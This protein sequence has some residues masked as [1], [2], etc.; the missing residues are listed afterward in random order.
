MYPTVTVLPQCIPYT[1]FPPCTV[2]PGAAGM[3]QGGVAGGVQPQT[4]FLTLFS[5][6]T[7]VCNAPVGPAGGGQPAG[8]QVVPQSTIGPIQC[9]AFGICSQTAGMPQGGQAAPQATAWIIQCTLGNICG[10][11]GAIPQGGQPGMM[12]LAT[13]C[14]QYPHCQ[15][16]GAMP[17]AT[18]WPIQCNVTIFSICTPICA[19]AGGGGQA[20]GMAQGGQAAP[21]ATAWIIQCT[22]FNVCGVAGG[23]MPQGGGFGGAQQPAGITVFTLCTPIC[24]QAAGGM[25][26]GGQAAP[27]ATAWIIQC[28]AFNVCG[29][30]GGGMPQG[31]AGGGTMPQATIGPVQCN[32]TIFSICT[33]ICG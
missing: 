12:T 33:P 22:A 2:A 29:V 6:C 18:F 14:T 5:L 8:G 9:T 1:Y 30:A 21:Q 20:A 25:A 16:A 4:M 32:V 13:I 27:Q 31:G 7:P 23:G 10:A 28:T 17:Q 24:A 26:Q 11:A 19:Q 3:P 15:Q